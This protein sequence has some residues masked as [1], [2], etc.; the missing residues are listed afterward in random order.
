MSMVPVAL[1]CAHLAQRRR[2]SMRLVR[3]CARFGQMMEAQWRLPSADAVLTAFALAM[4][5]S[6][7]SDWSIGHPTKIRWHAL[8]GFALAGHLL[9]HALNRRKRLETSRVR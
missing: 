1:V 7:F 9:V 6:G 3:Q 5:A 2:S 8:M 4:L